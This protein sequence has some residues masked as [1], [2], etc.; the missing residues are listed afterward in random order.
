M[1]SLYLPARAQPKRRPSVAEVT[2]WVDSVTQAQLV[3]PLDSVAQAR[4]E[5][6]LGALDKGG[7]FGPELAL[8]LSPGVGVISLF[9]QDAQEQLLPAELTFEQLSLELAPAPTFLPLDD[10]E[11]EVSCSRCGDELPL[12]RLERALDALSFQPFEAVTLQCLSC[13]APRGLRELSY[14]REVGFASAWLHIEECGSSRLNPVMLK[15]WGDALGAPLSLIVDQR[16]PVLDWQGGEEATLAGVDHLGPGEV[17]FFERGLKPSRALRRRAQQKG[18]G[19]NK[20][21]GRGR[22]RAPSWDEL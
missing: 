16:D 22:G 8:K 19:A 4:L 18:R 12:E 17:S 9:D 20:R 5:A 3:S 10:P 21:R 13:D 6:M 7:P 2:R 15:A 11:L 1:L 14:D